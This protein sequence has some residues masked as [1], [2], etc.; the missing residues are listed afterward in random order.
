MSELNRTNDRCDASTYLVIEG[1]KPQ[2][3]G[4]RA[5]AYVKVENEQKLDLLMCRHHFNQYEFAL[6]EQGFHPVVDERHTI[7]NVNKLIG[8]GLS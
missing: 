3:V 2:N 4:C 1:E 8:S 6:V 5:Q 7:E